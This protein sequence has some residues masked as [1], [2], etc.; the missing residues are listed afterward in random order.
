MTSWA[1]RDLPQPEVIW[2]MTG[3]SGRDHVEFSL[4]GVFMGGRHFDVQ[5]HAS[6]EPEEQ[7]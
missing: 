7:S 4:L 5:V 2:H 1:V 3:L 6:A